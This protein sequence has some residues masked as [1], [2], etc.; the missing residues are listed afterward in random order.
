MVRKQVSIY[1][2]GS[3]NHRTRTGNYSVVL[4][5]K[6]I[7]KT[8]T[9]E[10]TD[11]TVNRCIIQGVIDAIKLLKEPCEIIVV[12]AT[13]LGVKKALKG[14]GVNKE[15]IKEIFCLLEENNHVAKFE[16]KIGQGE[17]LSKFILSKFNSRVAYGK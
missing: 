9:A 13:A 2:L 10:I 15:L 5:Y 6:N 14:T 16:T 8:L 3:W 4:Q 1:S 11:T 7:H 12:T 17:Q